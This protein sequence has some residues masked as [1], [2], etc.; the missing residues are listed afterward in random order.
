ME[1][2]W[3]VVEQAVESGRGKRVT[4]GV[5]FGGARGGG[6]W[7]RGWVK[8]PGGGGGRLWGGVFVRVEFGGERELGFGGVCV[9]SS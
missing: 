8:K 3:G 9:M 6:C 4:W 1:S 5:G 7:G 2:K